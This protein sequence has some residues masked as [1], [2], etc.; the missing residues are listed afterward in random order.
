MRHQCTDHRN[1]GNKN[2]YN[3]HFYSPRFNCLLSSAAQKAGHFKML[4]FC[5]HA[6]QK[7]ICLFL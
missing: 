7:N 6:R 5:Q 4:T 1:S 2:Q 3:N